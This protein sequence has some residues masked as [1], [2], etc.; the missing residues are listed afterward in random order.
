[1]KQTIC[2]NRVRRVNAVKDELKKAKTAMRLYNSTHLEYR[3]IHTNDDS[4]NYN[5]QE[6]HDHWFQ[7][8]G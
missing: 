4:T 5:T 3:E 6:S 1:M 2:F 8:A 7:Q